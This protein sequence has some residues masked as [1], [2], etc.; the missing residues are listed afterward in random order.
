MIQYEYPYS[1][2]NLYLLCE[3]DPAGFP[4]AKVFNEHNAN[5]S[6]DREI[7]IAHKKTRDASSTFQSTANSSKPYA[8]MWPLILRFLA[9]QTFVHQK[10]SDTFDAS[11]D[12][13]AEKTKNLLWGF[14]VSNYW[15]YS[16]ASLYAM[17]TSRST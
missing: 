7:R 12:E 9:G 2:G 4:L 17:L 16:Q 10:G 1:E 8:W 6:L 13:I 14:T 15:W 5:A 3:Q 11:L